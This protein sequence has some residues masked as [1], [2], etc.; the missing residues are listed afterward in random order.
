MV[1]GKTLESD[2]SCPVCFGYFR[3]GNGGGGIGYHKRGRD[4]EPK[5]Y[6]IFQ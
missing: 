4:L 2:V 5:I 6:K 1:R 3:K